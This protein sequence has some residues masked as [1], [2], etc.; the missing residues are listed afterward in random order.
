MSDMFG[1]LRSLVVCTAA[2]ILLAVVFLSPAGAVFG[3]VNGLLVGLCVGLAEW[4]AQRA[5]MALVPV[6]PIRLIGSYSA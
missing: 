4:R 2:G 3:A 6:R 1:F 5:E